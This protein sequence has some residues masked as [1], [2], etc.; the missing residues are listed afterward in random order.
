MKKMILPMALVLATY[1][2]GLAGE[3]PATTTK[4]SAAG[5]IAIGARVSTLGIGPE[6]SLG[7]SDYFSSR[8]AVHWGTYDVEGET[9]GVT[10]D[11]ELELFS[12][13][14]TVEWFPW[15]GG[16]HIDAGLLAN[17]NNFSGTGKPA[18]GGTYTFDN[19]TYTATEAGTVTVDVDF[20]SVAPYVGL[21]WGNPIDNDETIT[22]F[23]NIGI[24][25]QGT[26]DVSIKTSGTLANDPLFLS[27]VDAEVK[28]LEDDLDSFSMYPVIALGVTY[29]F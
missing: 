17:G 5:N 19:V 4:E 22:F 10:Y 8:V 23:A 13:L 7:L 27:R 9:D 28:E 12:G 29:K 6:I 26:P 2:V 15:A 18:I 24:V 1:G 25:F 16:F 20:N 3:T 11:C 14:A 21:G